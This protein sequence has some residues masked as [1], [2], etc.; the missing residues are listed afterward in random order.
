MNTDTDTEAILRDVLDRWRAGVDAHRPQQVATLF[1]EDA[2]FQ[3]LRPYS[4]GRPGVAAYYGSQPAG[5]T[6]AYRIVE[7]RALADDLVLGYLAVDFSFTDRPTLHVHLG[8][9]VKRTE[10]G[11]RIAH[12]QVSR[13]D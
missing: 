3:G 1:T 9:L 7:S 5:L 12:Y 4:V 10:E 2:I 11:W 13:L 8:V 6:A